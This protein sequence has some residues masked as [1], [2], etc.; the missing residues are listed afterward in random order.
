MCGKH[1]SKK[2]LPVGNTNGLVDSRTR[3]RGLGR[4]LAEGFHLE[5][6]KRNLRNWSVPYMNF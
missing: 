3:T 2:G 4:R 6:K 5:V 1:F